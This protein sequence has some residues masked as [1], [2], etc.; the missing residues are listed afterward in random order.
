MTSKIDPYLV[1]I[2]KSGAF[3][4]SYSTNMIIMFRE[5]DF[6]SGVQALNSMFPDIVVNKV[7]DYIPAIAIESPPS[8]IQKIASLPQVSKVWYDYPIHL[9]PMSLKQSDIYSKEVAYDTEIEDLWAKNLSG[10]GIIIALLDSGIDTNHPDLDDLDDN[11]STFDPKVI[12]SVSMVE[13]DPYTFDFNG[14]GTYVAGIIAGTGNAS[15]GTY[16][17]IAP[18]AQLLNVK[19]FDI[20]GLSFFSWVLSGVEWSVS[21]GADIIIVPF[22]G[23]GY[24]DDPLC[25]AVD[26]AVKSGVTVIAAA[27]D[28]GP[29]YTSVGSPG[30]ALSPITVGS[31]NT[32]SGLVCFNSSRGPSLFMWTDPDLVAPGYNITSCKASPPNLGVN[33]SFPS[34]PTGGYGTPLNENGNYTTATGTL[35]ATAYAAG[36]A[37]LLLQAFPFLSPEALRV[38]MMRTAIDLGEDPNTQGA[39]RLD[40]NATYNYLK[41]LEGPLGNI[42]RVFTPALPYTGFFFTNDTTSQMSTYCIVGTYGTFV[43]MQTQNTTS[44]FNSTHLLQGRFGVKYNGS[45][46]VTLFLLT[47]VY[48]EM[49]STTIPGEDYQRALTVLGNEN[50]LIVI[51]VDCWNS[52]NATGAFRI[53]VTLVNIGSTALT[54]VSL[55]TCWDIDLFLNES[56]YTSDDHAQYNSTDDLIYA[57]NS[58][59]NEPLTEF[60]YV[61]FKSNTTSTAHE[62]G[63]NNTVLEHF[64]NDQLNNYSSYDDG[65]VGLAMKWNLA[66]Q[67]DPG[68]NVVFVGALGVGGDYSQMWDA[69]NNVLAAE[70]RNVTDLCVVNASIGRNGKVYTPFASESV[71]LNIGSMVTNATV[72]FFSNKSTDGS[73]IIYT[74]IFQYQNIQPFAFK[75][76]ST[77]WE[78]TNS[79]VYSVGW[80]TTELP[81]F[82]TL[83][84]IL[85]GNLT[86][87]MS[88]TYLLD[89]FIARNVFVGDPPNCIILFPTSIPNKPFELNFPLD[90]AYSN[91]TIVSSYHLEN[92]QVAYSGNATQLF[93]ETPTV[94]I[95][96]NYANILISFN[97]TYFP[98]PGYYSGLISIT[99]NGEHLG[100]VNISFN[101]SYPEGRLFFDSIHNE[102]GLESWGRRL[103]S[104][105]SG[106][107]QFSE[108]I[109]KQ[110][111][112]IDEIPFLTEYNSTLLSFYD[113]IL[114]FAPVKGF[115]PQE[116]ATLHSLLNNGTSILICVDPENECN[117]TAVNMITQ[118]YGITVVANETG[119]IIITS[120]N[121]SQSHPVTSNLSSIEMDSV[122]ILNVSTGLG[123]VALAN[124]SNG[125]VIAAAN[126]G[127][128]KLLVIGDSSIF[129]SRHL[130]LSDNARL[131]LNAINWLL[132]NRMILNV[133]VSSPNPGGILYIGDNLYASIHI[134]DIHGNDISSNI[135]IFTIFVLP[136]GTIFPM[137]AFHYK[138]GW[139]TTFFFTYFTNKTGDYTMVIYAD[140]PNYTT[141]HYIY[142]FK[143]E[144][145]RL[146]VPPL[147][148]FPQA[149]REYAIFGFTF[150]GVITL[151]AGSAYLLERRR[152][153]K[154]TLIPELD[155]DLRNTIRNTVNEVR[156]VNKEIDREL[157]KKDIDDFDRIRIIHEKLRRL[158]K[159]LDKAKKVAERVG[160]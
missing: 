24:P 123:A 50:M 73:S 53:T 134:T 103:Y 39:G 45:D 132:E 142:N 11:S 154:K 26:K 105:Y 158:R 113:G 49:H 16:K 97:A 33:I 89:N 72:F 54:D 40:A 31:Y 46:N 107:F 34:I 61:G 108:E 106:Y 3:P 156:A 20:E 67:L 139:Y 130:N 128:G 90:F 127:Y 143:V 93:N 60:I 114:I 116:N 135:T 68:S 38:G 59:Y 129:D 92:V 96:D 82:L 66:G 9:Q 75:R 141:T 63:E 44:G 151:I 4:D 104:I 77:S 6:S 131:A 25:T 2:I 35:A 47:T 32:S 115:T 124:T 81:N 5:T 64:L 152:L 95:R 55:L 71:V 80:V 159:A 27:G 140:A 58:Y 117:W 120:A 150:L 87:N 138:E 121:M 78:P 102:I 100:N 28:D 74:E 160:E 23:P 18:Q 88:E 22:A 1:S 48:R 86:F 157:S 111:H 153:R 69:I 83:E 36:A 21:H 19:V 136:N 109:F 17:G 57:N 52:T 37:A 118:P 155:R 7:Y 41:N 145:A 144:P 91:L 29:A 12:A 133:E 56:I 43:G 122:A 147:F 99:A 125:T 14:H 70:V 62:V 101:L 98:R 110:G 137:F 79:G 84:Q 112:D 13:Y 119:T 148:Y 126:A 76:I 10:S 15:N 146:T 30:M 94:L 42:T 51:S 8:N 149:S 65:N 85:S